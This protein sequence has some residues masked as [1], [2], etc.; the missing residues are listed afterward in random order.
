[1]EE[2]SEDEEEA[3]KVETEDLAQEESDTALKG[4]NEL[5]WEV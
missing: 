5:G 4:E 2:E 3:F 1:M